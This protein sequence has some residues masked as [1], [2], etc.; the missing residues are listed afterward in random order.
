M[1]VMLDFDLFQILSTVST[2]EF[3][4]E[5]LRSSLT[6]VHDDNHTINTIDVISKT[7][8]PHFSATIT[9]HSSKKG[10]RCLSLHLITR[11]NLEQTLIL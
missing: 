9:V 10:F 2:I 1:Q 11:H 6:P 8:K 7:Y 5:T 4:T 3:L